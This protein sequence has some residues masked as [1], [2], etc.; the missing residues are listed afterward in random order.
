MINTQS[1]KYILPILLFVLPAA[2]IAKQQ[3]KEQQVYQLEYLEREQ[4]VDEYETVMLVSDRFIRVDQT[5]EA[6]GYI[7]YDDSKKVIYSVSHAD[8]SVLV[9]K[10]QAF[11]EADSPVK[12][13]VEYLQLADAPKISD[14]TVFNYRVHVAGDDE[15]TCTEVQLAENLLP[16]VT[17]ML[18]NYQLVV[19]GQQARMTDNKI[20]DMQTACYYID[21]IYNTGAYYDKALPI[22]EW[23]S[24]ESSKILTSYKEISVSSDKFTIPENYRQFS[25]GKNSKTVIE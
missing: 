22:Q 6:D 4:G 18:K 17:G 11:S 2:V 20:T 25:I 10:Q 5:G 7:I 24:N 16:E 21:Q 12:K 23:H 1:Y 13:Q 15:E 19:S 14:H 3:N 9:I 8:K